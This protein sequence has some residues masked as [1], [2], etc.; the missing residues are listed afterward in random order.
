MFCLLRRF[1]GLEFLKRPRSCVGIRRDYKANELYIF[2][3]RHNLVEW[4]WNFK[5]LAD[6]VLWQG[7]RMEHG[8]KFKLWGAVHSYA[9][10]NVHFF[11]SSLANTTL[12]W[13]GLAYLRY[14]V[15]F[16]DITWFFFFFFFAML[17]SYNR[18]IVIKL[19]S[20]WSIQQVQLLGSDV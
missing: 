12:T 19:E 11:F 4:S 8:W 17:A 1:W 6:N 20:F 3:I 15:P 5:L 10:F 9:G 18:R 16:Y 2:P 13:R 14:V 7:C